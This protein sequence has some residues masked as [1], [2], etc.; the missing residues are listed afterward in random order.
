MD[1]SKQRI[2]S[3]RTKEF[4]TKIVYRE[5]EA[6]GSFLQE[7]RAVAQEKLNSMDEAFVLMKEGS[8]AVAELVAIM[9]VPLETQLDKIVDM[10]TVRPILGAYLRT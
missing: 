10:G 4:W 9:S 3:T 7:Y 1:K 5:I 2:D 8:K 6:A